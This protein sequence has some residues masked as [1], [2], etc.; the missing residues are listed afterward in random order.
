MARAIAIRLPRAEPIWPALLLV[1]MAALVALTLALG[2]RLSAS[3]PPAVTH[4]VD[5]GSD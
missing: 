5:A 2:M 4:P 1:A 3:V